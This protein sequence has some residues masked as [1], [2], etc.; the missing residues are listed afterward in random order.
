LDNSDDVAEYLL[1][2]AEVVTASGRAFEQ[3]GYLRLSFAV[4]ETVASDGVKAAA[5]ALGRLTK[6]F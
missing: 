2:S 1:E 3:D 4:A 5:E 6:P